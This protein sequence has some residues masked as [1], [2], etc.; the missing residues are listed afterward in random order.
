M[1]FLLVEGYK[2]AADAFAR[3][4]TLP[5][6]TTTMNSPHSTLTISARTTLRHFLLSGDIS[7]AISL[8]ND[9]LP[10]LLDN[11]PLLSARLHLQLL[12]EQVRLCATT[13]GKQGVGQVITVARERVAPTIMTA[14]S[15]AVNKESAAEAQILLADFNKTLAV[16]L[17]GG[18]RVPERVRQVMETGRRAAV[19]ASANRAV[20]EATGQEAE[21]VLP[22]LLQLQQLIGTK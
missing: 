22:K 4:S 20:L 3:E 11:S 15:N 19:A 6:T 9:L 14:V 18:E 13:S 17:V 21:S 5:T 8:L 7:S 16:L 2:E 10:D 12:I 1:N